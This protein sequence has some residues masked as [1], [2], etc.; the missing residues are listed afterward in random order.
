M[1][2][3]L[4][5]VNNSAYKSRIAD[6]RLS[7]YLK[8]F[9]AV[10][11]EGP[12]WCGK[13]WTALHQAASAYMIADPTDNFAAHERVALDINIAFPGAEPHLIDEWQELPALR[14]VY[15]TGRRS[16]FSC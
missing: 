6:S 1:L 8:S 16:R 3:I 10:C 13:T 7:D 2:H 4:A 15:T 14:D 5:N 9:G 11:I 12:K